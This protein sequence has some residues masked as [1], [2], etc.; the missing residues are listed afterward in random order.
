[1]K[2]LPKSMNARFMNWSCRCSGGYVITNEWSKNTESLRS[3]WHQEPLGFMILWENTHASRAFPGCQGCLRLNICHSSSLGWWYIPE[4]K[5]SVADRWAKK[6]VAL[7]WFSCS[8]LL[9][10]WCGP[11]HCL[12]AHGLPS[13]LESLEILGRPHGHPSRWAGGPD[14]EGIGRSRS[15]AL[16]EFVHIL[17]QGHD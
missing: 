2:A 3:L 4:K 17:R 11:R 16:R 14:K 10:A 15:N 12:S 5:R 9:Q 7:T 13:R 1:M 8:C 6:L